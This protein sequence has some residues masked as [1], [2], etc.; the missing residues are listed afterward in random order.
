MAVLIALSY[1]GS[2]I[3]ITGTIAFDSFPAFFG[4]LALGGVYG[5]IIG[6][7]GHLFTAFLSGFPF[8]LPIHLVIASMM[9]IS[10]YLFG[11]LARKTNI[12]AAIVVAII[13]NGPVS[14]FVSAYFM[15]AGAGIKAIM[16]IFIS[17]VLILSLASAI[18]V[19][20]ASLVYSRVKEHI[21][22]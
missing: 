11:I 6:F 14:L 22:L 21:N 17:L 4:A 15:A 10:V 18:N 9:F 19:I 13:M 7:L 20:A 12:F 16:G 1:I 3:K 8:T 2:L 5:G